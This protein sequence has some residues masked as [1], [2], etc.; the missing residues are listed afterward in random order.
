MQSLGASVGVGGVNRYGDVVL[1]QRRLASIGLS[2]GRIDGKCGRR[3][4][5]AIV[6][7]QK[8]HLQRPDGRI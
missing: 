8:G 2:P 6:A 3:T 4:V 5:S 1:I 7:F